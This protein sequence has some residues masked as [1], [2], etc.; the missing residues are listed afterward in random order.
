MSTTRPNIQLRIALIL[1]AGVLITL[2]GSAQDQYADTVTGV[3]TIIH[4]DAIDGSL[5]PRTVIFLHTGSEQIRLDMDLTTAQGLNRQHVQIEGTRSG[6]H[7][8]VGRATVLSGS[9]GIRGGGGGTNVPW[10]TLLCRYSDSPD[11]TPNDIPW[12]EG[13]LGST[14]PGINHYWQQISYNYANING[15]MVKGWYNL[16]QPKSYYTAE[17]GEIDWNRAAVDCTAVADM[18]VDFNQFDG[19]NLWFNDDLGCCA[20]GGT[21]NLDLDGGWRIYSMTWMGP[22][23]YHHHG[24]VAHEMGHGFGLPHSAASDGTTAS[25][26]DVMSH[27]VAG[28][29]LI[30]PN[31]GCIGVGTISYHLHKLGWIPKEY[32]KTIQLGRRGVYT[33]ERLN[34]PPVSDNLRMIRIPINGSDTHYYT[35]EARRLYGYD[36]HLPGE[37]VII[38]EVDTNRDTH[39]WL[40]DPN[41]AADPHDDSAMWL[42]GETFEDA[43]NHIRV[44]VL[45]NDATGFSVLVSNNAP[46]TVCDTVSEIPLSECFA[47]DALYTQTDGGNWSG[48]TGWMTNDTPC[49]W[50][51]VTCTNGH[52]TTLELSGKGLSGS[53]P[54]QIGDLPYVERLDLSYNSLNGS[55]PEGIGDM[56]ALV[57]LTLNDNQISG[58]LPSSMGNLANLAWVGLWHNQIEGPLPDTFGTLPKLTHFLAGV[59]KISGSI[60]TTFGLSDTLTH[61]D[62]SYNQ[63]EGPLPSNLADLTTLTFINLRYNMLDTSDSSLIALLNNLDPDTLLTQ[64]VPPDDLQLV[65]QDGLTVRLAWSPIVYSGDAGYYEIGMRSSEADSFEVVAQTGSKLD[66]GTVVTLQPGYTYEIAVRSFTDAHDL[67]QT[68]LRSAYSSGLT[69]TT[70]ENLILNGGFETQGETQKLPANW[71][72]KNLTKDKRLCNKVLE[73]GTIKTKAYQGE[74]AFQFKGGPGGKSK[75]KQSVL[76]QGKAG[77]TVQFGL[78]ARGK[79]LNAGAKVKLVIR[80]ADGESKIKSVI[81]P[82]VLNG[83]SYDYTYLALTEPL[84]QDVSKINLKIMMNALSGKLRVDDVSLYIAPGTGTLDVDGLLPLPDSWRGAR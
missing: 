23:A 59:N 71:T 50:T 43:A 27:S 18:D 54:D 29:A 47:L 22:G 42:P 55:I 74:C 65:A 35:V 77:D 16:P 83:G 10:V 63:L 13:L 76:N 31:Y 20:W 53:I 30:D 78:W 38:Y 3:L 44:R 5:P 19:I 61:L 39:A 56:V 24:T 2:T 51:G 34:Q 66:T 33:L 68:P 9:D 40:V 75:I 11:L 14:Y 58:P 1:I 80:Y 17:S 8:S 7:M 60:P 52:I 45:D 15:S 72:F 48:V 37:A 28:C 46:A 67:Q 26:W 64:T 57:V 62:L 70:P 21:W 73:D 81:E 82:Q 41:G 69:V 12:F 32:R 6:D 49:S 25:Y 84:S 79:N 36:D 4:G